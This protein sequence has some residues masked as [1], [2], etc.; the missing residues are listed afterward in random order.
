MFK[1]IL[2]ILIGIV[3]VSCEKETIDDV[4]N[5]IISNPSSN[6]IDDVYNPIIDNPSS[7]TELVIT[8]S[9]N[10]IPLLGK[11]WTTI[12][13]TIYNSHGNMVYEIEG[14]RYKLLSGFGYIEESE[15][16]HP[17]LFKQVNNEW[18][19]FKSFPEIGMEGVR[20][21][22]T[23]NETTF[24]WAE[25]PEN[26]LRT[27]LGCPI[28]RGGNAWLV[29]VI[30]DDVIFTKINSETNWF[31]D[32]SYGDLDNDGLFD[33]V[34]NSNDVYFQNQDGTFRLEKDIFPGTAGTVYFTIEI[35]DLFGDSQPE[36]VMG[37]YLD[38]EYDWQKRGFIVYQFN[39]ETRKM[40]E[41]LRK[42]NPLLQGDLGGNYTQIVD[43]N[44]D[45]YNDIV[46]GREGPGVEHTQTVEIWIGNGTTDL[47][48]YDVIGNF[49]KFIMVGFELMDINNDNFL[50][51]VFR[52]GG[53]GSIRVGT[54]FEEG[55]R[56]NDLIWI[57]DGTGKFNNYIS[58]ELV[59]GYGT[60][61]E[62]F[63]PY[64]KDG[65]LSFFGGLTE[66]LNSDYAKVT[67]W[68]IEIK[69]L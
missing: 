38:A 5:P 52:G 40:E 12:S 33:I 48:P 27:C 47:I 32:I 56:L 9:I 62:K 36:I 49:N 50:D 14:E 51:I 6:T 13:Q 28:A 55:F 15:D 3:L 63:V 8:Q 24:I 25:A 60:S 42:Q 19:Y 58:T 61:I 4:Y 54:T 20:N 64:M 35:G 67:T 53:G 69:N 23:I 43:I 7:N 10:E 1:K 29:K 30:K 59:G 22:R 34:W 26:D 39:Q 65:N 16:S 44:N 17:I 68:D 18:K 66:Q 45:G 37:A 21:H 46:M 11:Q 2:L 57:N 31:H 41:V